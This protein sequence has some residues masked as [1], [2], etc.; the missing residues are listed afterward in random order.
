[1]SVHGFEIDAFL[2]VTFDEASV[3]VVDLTAAMEQIVIERPTFGVPR[4][5]EGTALDEIF[6]LAFCLISYVWVHVVGEELALQHV[7]LIE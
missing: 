7:T 2:E 6:D 3:C 1:M 4:A 5:S